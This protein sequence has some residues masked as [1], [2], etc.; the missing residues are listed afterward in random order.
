[1]HAAT[2]TLCSLSRLLRYSLTDR[3]T[4]SISLSIHLY[5]P[6]HR[7]LFCF[8]FHRHIY[9]PLHHP[10]S[11]HTISFTT[12]PLPSAFTF[13]PSFAHTSLSQVLQRLYLTMRAQ[14]SLGN[15]IPVT[16]RHLESLIRLSQARARLDLREV[17]AV[18]TDYVHVLCV[19]TTCTYCMHGLCACSSCTLCT[20]QSCV[21]SVAFMDSFSFDLIRL[22]CIKSSIVI[23]FL[24]VW[25]Y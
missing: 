22:Q 23:S 18:C 19:R 16:T 10:A 21:F 14:S 24:P 5:L 9:F 3:P 15:S 6:F 8:P 2:A 11:F 12:L 1:M 20:V 17:R 25:C 7:H 13:T 4:L